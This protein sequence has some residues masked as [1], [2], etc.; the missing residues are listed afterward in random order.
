MLKASEQA[1]KLSGGDQWLDHVTLAVARKEAE[2][3][4]GAKEAL[5]RARDLGAEDQQKICDHVADFIDNDK[6]LDW[7]FIANH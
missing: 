2:D 7:K 5:Q 6:P 3:T 4:A 1:S